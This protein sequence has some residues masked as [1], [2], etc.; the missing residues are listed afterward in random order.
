MSSRH[1]FGR[2]QSGTFCH[3]AG[4]SNAFGAEG[5]EASVRSAGARLSIGSIGGKPALRRNS[6]LDGIVVV[7][8]TGGV[9]AGVLSLRG[10]GAPSFSSAFLNLSLA[11][12]LP[13]CPGR[14]FFAAKRRV[15][16]GRL[17]LPLMKP[18]VLAARS[19]T[20]QTSRRSMALRPL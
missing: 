5:T 2:S 4:I 17:L 15:S 20:A 13:R 6:T 11:R 19:A 8:A 12:A 3:L 9:G 10:G 14:G 18:P 7:V 16:A 1:L